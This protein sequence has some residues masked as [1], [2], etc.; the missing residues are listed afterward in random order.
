MRARDA[1]I[2]ESMNHQGL[3]SKVQMLGQCFFSCSLLAI[4]SI[5]AT[6]LL[7]LSRCWFIC[8][9]QGFHLL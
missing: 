7:M 2:I 3:K 4:L 5:P 8:T 9:F 1:S 6:Y